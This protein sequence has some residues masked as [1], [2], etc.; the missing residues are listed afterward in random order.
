[1]AGIK[2]A[3]GRPFHRQMKD[4]FIVKKGKKN[5]VVTEDISL[6]QLEK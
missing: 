5:V 4:I 1:M 3:S 6:C 2:Q